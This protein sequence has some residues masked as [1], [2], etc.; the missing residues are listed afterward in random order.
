[1]IGGHR[2]RFNHV[3]SVRYDSWSYLPKL[4]EGHNLAPNVCVNYQDKAIF[5][6]MTDARLNIKVA[7]MDLQ[8]AER[9]PMPYDKVMKWALVLPHYFH[10]IDRFHLKSAI[11]LADGR[12]AVY[13]RGRPEGI[14]EQIMTLV[15]FF[16]V[17]SND[18]GWSLD[19]DDYE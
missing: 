15:L 12:V 14:K 5:T 3:Y 9:F 4:P 6:F 19:F 7:A 2:D 10:K 16:R 18:E 1:M 17:Y 8:S 11:T 13:A